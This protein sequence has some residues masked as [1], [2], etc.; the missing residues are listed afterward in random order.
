MDTG[1]MF[2]PDLV[3]SKDGIVVFIQV[4]HVEDVKNIAD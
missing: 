4:G 1:N 3:A 2:L